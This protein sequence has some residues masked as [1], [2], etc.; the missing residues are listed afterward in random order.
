MINDEIDCFETE[1]IVCPYCGHIQSDSWEYA[2]EDDCVECDECEKEFGYTSET[3]RLFTSYTKEE[4]EKR[5]KRDKES[6]ERAKRDLEEY[7][8][9]EK[10]GK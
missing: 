10:E 2:D 5:K 7:I 8:K 3:Q 6:M 4:I 9:K 1:E